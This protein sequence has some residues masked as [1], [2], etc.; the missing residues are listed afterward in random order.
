MLAYRQRGPLRELSLRGD[1]VISICVKQ[2]L[3]LMTYILV[4]C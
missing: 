2:V 4:C 1:I 3:L